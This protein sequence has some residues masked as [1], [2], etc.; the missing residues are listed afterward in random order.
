MENIAFDCVLFENCNLNCSHCF[1]CHTDNMIDIEYIKNL[2]TIVYPYLTEEIEKKNPKVVLFS[3]RGGEIFQDK[4]SDEIIGYYKKF[5]LGVKDRFVKDYPNKEIRFHIMSNGVYNKVDRVIK[6]LEEV[7]G[8]ITLSYDAFGRFPSQ[9]QYEMFLRS[10]K[11]LLEKNLIKNIAI[12]LT[13]QSIEYYIKNKDKLKIFSDSEIDFNY[14]VPTM[15]ES[16]LPSDID[17][18]NFYKYLI[19][20][21]IYNCVYIKNI[22]D[23]IIYKTKIYSSCNCGNTTV[24]YKGVPYHSC[25]IYV[26]QLK[27]NDFYDDISTLTEANAF[28][29]ILNKGFNKRQCLTCPQFN[30]CSYYCWMMLCYKNYQLSNCPHRMIY[31]Y[32][33]NN[34]HILEDYKI[35]KHQ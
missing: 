11:L 22:L 26:P 28:K 14:Y 2:D 32:I 18:F 15:R 20:N 4:I 16:E 30:N 10:Y 5:I 21:K 19:D 6:L 34:T 13:K 33:T 29:R 31:N 9:I 7:D 12:T 23:N 3:I 25:N 35:W 8:K 27:L 17:L 1:Q 24:F